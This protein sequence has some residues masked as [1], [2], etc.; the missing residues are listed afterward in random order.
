M[1]TNPINDSWEFLS[2]VSGPHLGTGNWRFLLVAVFWVALAASIAIAIR[3]W[4]ADPAQRISGHFWTWFFRVMIGV[5]WFEGSLWKLP[6]PSGGFQYWLGQEGEFAAFG[7]YKELVKNVLLPNYALLNWPVFLAE[8]GM[9]L[10]FILGLGVRLFAIIGILFTTQLYFGLYQHPSEWPWLYVFLIFVQGF[11]LI[12]AAGRS[13]GLDALIRRE[14]F[15]PFKGDGLIAR[16][17][18]RAS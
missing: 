6:I 10:S 4:R 13:L 3:N 16:L 8:M 1:R 17:Y 5:M 14:P 15:G 9:A 7:F 18:R 12:H 11:F 2:G